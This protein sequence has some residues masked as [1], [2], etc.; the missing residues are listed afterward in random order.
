MKP[1]VEGTEQKEQLVQE[2]SRRNGEDRSSH[3]CLGRAPFLWSSVK[4]GKF[5]MRETE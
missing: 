3:S 1:E 2:A 4:E 5:A